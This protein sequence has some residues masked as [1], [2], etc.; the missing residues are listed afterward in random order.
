[1]RG[2][3]Q[4]ERNQQIVRRYRASGQ[5]W[6]ATA[7]QMAAW[8]IRENLWAAHRDSLIGQCAEQLAEAM[9]EEY[10]VDPQGRNVRTKHAA[11]VKLHGEQLNLWED[12]RTAD[13]KYMQIAFQQR[14]QQI[15]GDCRQLK[16]DVDSFND[17]ANTERPI[18]MVFDFAQDLAEL[19][20]MDALA[21]QK[22]PNPARPPSDQCPS[23]A[24]G[25]DPAPAPARPS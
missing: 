19:D 7:K 8:A 6:P 18:Q 15:V 2:Q 20:V 11:R 10:Y 12:I 3:T 4:I 24:R 17:N 21:R 5:A 1:M 25:W 14:R 9:R 23:A 16:N 13:R 22:R